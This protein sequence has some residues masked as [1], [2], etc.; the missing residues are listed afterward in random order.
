MSQKNHPNLNWAGKIAHFFIKNAQLSMLVVVTVFAWGLLSFFMTP[1]QYDPEIT[2]PAYDIHLYAPSADSEE[3][4][5]RITRVFEDEILS[6][7]GVEDVISQTREGGSAVVSVNFFV[8]EDE[9]DSTIKLRQK[10]DEVRNNVPVVVN[11]VERIT[12]D[13]KDPDDIPVV[14][15]VLTSKE[16]SLLELRELAVHYADILKN[17]PGVTNVQVHGG[18]KRELR[19]TLDPSKLAEYKIDPRIVVGKIGKNSYRA[20]VSDEF[21]ETPDSKEIRMIEVDGLFE[22]PQQAENIVIT[23]ADGRSILLKDIATIE[24][25]AEIPKNYTRYRTV[26]SDD[27]NAVYLS[28][29]KADGSNI[30]S[31][32]SGIKDRVDTLNLPE[33]VSFTV[34]RDDGEIAGKEVSG[35]TQSLFMA[36]LIVIAVLFLFLGPRV[37]ITTALAIPLTISA[38]FGVALLTGQTINRITLFALI[39]SLGLLIDNA[40]VVVE[41]SVRH[42]KMRNEEKKVAVA[43]AVGEVGSGLLLATLTTLFAFFP[44]LFVTGMMGPYMGPIPFF[45]PVALVAS[46]IIAY[47]LNPFL[48]SRIVKSKTEIPEEKSGA[49]KSRQGRLSESFYANY[50]GLLYK[51]FENRN[52]RRGL[53]TS[54]AFLILASVSLPLVQAVKFRMLPKDDKE[55]LFVYVDYK[56][57]TTLE[58]NLEITEKLEQKILENKDIESVQ[59][60]IATAPVVDFNGAFRGVG[61]R[62][63]KNQAT[64]KVNLSEERSGKSEEV[65]KA[66]RPELKSI[67]SN[68]EDANIIMVE[69]A[70]GPPVRSTAM[71]KVKGIERSNITEDNREK[72][73]LI[74]QDFEK[75]FRDT[76][77]IVDVDTNARDPIKTVSFQVDLKKAGEIGLL[78]KDIADNLDI[79]LNGRVATLYRD[80]VDKER[81]NIFV[82]FDKNLEQD[83]DALRNL[84]INY[85]PTAKT[86]L[87]EQLF[88]VQVD[89]QVRLGDVVEVKEVN[90]DNFIPSENRD[91]MYSITGEMEDRSVTY[92][93]IEI[94][95]EIWNYKLPWTDNSERVGFS[96]YGAEFVDNDTGMRYT[97]EWDGEW[98]L[99][100]DVFRDLGLA[101]MVAIFLIYGILVAQFRSFKKALLILSTVPLG[102][103]GVMSGYVLLNLFGGLYFNATSMIGVIALSGIVVNN[104]IIMVECLNQLQREGKEFKEALVETASIRLRPIA[105]T[106]IT[107]ILGS[108]TLVTDPVW[109]GLGWSIALGMTASTVLMLVIFPAVYYASM[110]KEYIK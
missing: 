108:L 9:E 7:P 20:F 37:A 52:L 100:L 23:K 11:R 101:M 17:E 76:D 22:S 2:A 15:L 104:A 99:T 18:E 6:V 51:I 70:P 36:I 84:T 77:G 10:V 62:I 65:A 25:A 33:G 81:E 58:E 94:L 93:A 54:T 31:V 8:G 67:I 12:I 86:T 49:K 41:N 109:A 89:R 16:K 30:T 19:V 92:S 40:I 24:Y 74:A 38:V 21:T 66:L 5:D 32:S 42:I 47:T 110:K 79:A 87:N 63:E 60:F 46:L 48:I 78:T 29:A 102:I 103:I 69:D 26:V 34:V 90:R 44:M 72:I 61:N 106:A 85:I 64:I 43:R 98:E 68:F 3:F 1:K 97:I 27:L 73:K 55:K 45:V 39:L 82:T 95:Q 57:G 80:S 91:I 53:I 50:R 107:T 71:V 35:L 13:N 88:K 83:I 28:L 59:T 75:I 14:T 105:L 4:Y 96:L 56:P